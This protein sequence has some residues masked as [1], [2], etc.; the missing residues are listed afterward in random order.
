M[1]R[2]EKAVCSYDQGSKEPPQ[3]REGSTW[4]QP[5]LILIGEVIGN[6]RVKCGV[7]PRECA[8]V[9]EGACF[10]SESTLGGLW[11]TACLREEREDNLGTLQMAEK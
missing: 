4:R 6:V 3:R 7:P 11:S 1:E 10:S 8:P 2:N 9:G 5:A